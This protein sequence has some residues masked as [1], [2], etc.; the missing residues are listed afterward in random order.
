MELFF[1]AF[2]INLPFYSSAGSNQERSEVEHDLPHMAPNKAKVMVSFVQAKSQLNMSWTKA[3][4]TE[5]ARR[6][7]ES[8][9]SQLVADIEAF[10]ELASHFVTEDQFK[11]IVF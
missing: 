9:C 2:N 1:S 10:S 6:V 11:M 5:N 4:K 7:I 8:A 3:N